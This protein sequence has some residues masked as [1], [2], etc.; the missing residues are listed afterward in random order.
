MT[1]NQ[2]AR[3]IQFHV[4]TSY[5]A[6]LLNRD[7]AGF[8]KRMPFGGVMRT[9]ISSQC[10]KK[11]WRTYADEH[12]LWRVEGLKGTNADT[13]PEHDS[14]RSRL[15]FQQKIVDPLVAEGAPLENARHAAAHVA[16]LLLVGTDTA[17]KGADKR[18]KRAQ[19]LL[20]GKDEPEETKEDYQVDPEQ[21]P[22]DGPE[23]SVA[24]KPAR[25]SGKPRAAVAP[26][27]AESEPPGEIKTAEVVVLG[28]AE[29]TFLLSLARELAQGGK[30]KPAEWPPAEKTADRLL[31]WL[32]DKN[33]AKNL[34]AMKAPGQEDRR[35]KG[36]RQSSHANMG[37]S[38]ALFGRMVT[39]DLFARGDAAI[40]VAHAFTVHGEQAESDYFSAMS[41]LEH[42]DAGSDHINA[43]ELT[44]GL[45]Y[46][47]VAVD[48][49]LLVDN[50]SGD[51]ALAGRVLHNLTHMLATVTP[52]AKLGSTAPHAAAHLL[53]AEAG[54]AQPRT[55]ANAFLSPV[56]PDEKA[57]ELL[58]RTYKALREEVLDS[59]ANFEPP[60]GRAL[61]VRRSSDLATSLSVPK[62]NAHGMG[63][64]AN[65][66]AAQVT[67]EAGNG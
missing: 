8:A 4:L 49:R 56:R 21:A 40:H 28:R 17:K 57:G 53:M 26:V 15:I 43:Q 38:A 33:N 48:V 3:F 54:D 42:G 30:E 12:S 44:S 45:F 59:D 6:S 16:A 1:E 25:T 24:D 35:K 2:Q 50:L 5:P 34:E 51:A 19:K 62:G 64:L 66:V 65:W 36:L 13:V 61:M 67:C 39:G 52:G 18:T 22:E 31:G 47:Y 37:L 7:D 9:R 20:T 55:F 58:E 46:S 32:K 23:A 41:N 14:L 10:L 27:V 60:R 11:H 29:V 63:E